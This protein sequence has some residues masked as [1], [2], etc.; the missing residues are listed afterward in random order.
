MDINLDSMFKKCTIT[1]KNDISIEA[2]IRDISDEGNTENNVQITTDI[3]SRYKDYLY[4]LFFN[5]YNGSTVLID[6][7]RLGA[8]IVVAEDQYRLVGMVLVDYKIT[9]PI[10]IVKDISRYDDIVDI[11]DF[12]TS[13]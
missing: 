6:D 5:P 11:D 7:D 12:I 2:I 1:T 8:F 10:A 9:N 3:I 13:K 4:Y